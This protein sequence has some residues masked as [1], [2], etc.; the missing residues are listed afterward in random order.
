MSSGPGHVNLVDLEDPAYK[1]KSMAQVEQ[2]VWAKDVEVLRSLGVNLSDNHMDGYLYQPAR[3]EVNKDWKPW[4]K[5]PLDQ[6]QLTPQTM[7]ADNWDNPEFKFELENGVCYMTINRPEANNTINGNVQT[8]LSNAVDILR[9]RPDVRVAT[10]TGAGRMFCAGADPRGMI[11][12]DGGPQIEGAPP[13]GQQITG[14]AESAYFSKLG[15]RAFAGILYKVANMSQFTI[16]CLNGSAMAGGVGFV[17]IVDMVIAVKQAYI[18]ISEVKLGMIPATIS[19]HVIGKM[20]VKNAK[21]L[22]CTAENIKAAAAMDIGL[23]QH[24][25]DG[26]EGFEPIIKDVCQKLQGVAPVALKSTKDIMIRTM[27]GTLSNSLLEY[28]ADEYVKSR[29]GPEAEVAMKAFSERKKPPWVETPIVPR[30]LLF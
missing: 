4:E 22:F 10:L 3:T 18:T 25:V 13:S 21:R 2:A 26:K 19:P 27:N 11:G 28:L 12:A 1:G 23:V 30:A 17:C 20:G 6:I 14:V 8:G 9:D 16:A 24:V 29:K 7:T 15:S 5:S